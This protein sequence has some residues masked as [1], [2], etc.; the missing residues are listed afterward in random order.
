MNRRALKIW[1][2]EAEARLIG[3]ACGFARAIVGA[4]QHALIYEEAP[5][6]VG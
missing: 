1:M 4:I 5:T 3:T 2:K 6:A